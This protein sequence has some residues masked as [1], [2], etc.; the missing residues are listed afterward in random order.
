MTTDVIFLGVISHFYF[1][2]TINI[3]QDDERSKTILLG[4]LGPYRQSAPDIWA[5]KCG[6]LSVSNQNPFDFIEGDL[7]IPAVIEAGGTD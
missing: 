6:H 1:A 7:V 5:K 4:C 3:R 2:A